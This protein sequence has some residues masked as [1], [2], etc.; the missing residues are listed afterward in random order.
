M[1]IE[2]YRLAG[3]VSRPLMV[4]QDKVRLATF[5]VR[6]GLVGIAVHLLIW[7][8]AG[9]CEVVSRALSLIINQAFGAMALIEQVPTEHPLVSPLELV[10]RDRG[11]L[12]YLKSTQVQVVHCKGCYFWVRNVVI[13]EVL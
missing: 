7:L 13:D 12:H 1:G 10:L 4:L 5:V 2:L 8:F 6:I 11:R 3:I 9:C